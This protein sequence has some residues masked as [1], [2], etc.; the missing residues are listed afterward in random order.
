M[1]ARARP[2]PAGS[3][4]GVGSGQLLALRP[5]SLDLL[6]L[7]K[8]VPIAPHL[9]LQDPLAGEHLFGMFPGGLIVDAL[10]ETAS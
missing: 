2:S 4:R 6:D 8:E 10:D 3:K 7:T 1:M 9:N 5:R